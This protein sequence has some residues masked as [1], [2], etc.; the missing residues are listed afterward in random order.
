MLEQGDLDEPSTKKIEQRRKIAREIRK[1][2]A[3]GREGKTLFTTYLQDTIGEMATTFST[4]IFATRWDPNKPN[5]ALANAVAG[6]LAFG[7]ELPGDVIAAQL[8]LVCAGERVCTKRGYEQLTTV[9]VRC[10]AVC[11]TNQDPRFITGRTKEDAGADKA[12]GRRLIALDFN[13]SF[14]NQPEADDNKAIDA[15]SAELGQDHMRLATMHFLLDA[16]QL[17]AECGF[18]LRWPGI[19]KESTQRVL[20]PVKLMVGTVLEVTP[21]DKKTASRMENARLTELVKEEFP[22]K[23]FGDRDLASWVQGLLVE[24]DDAQPAAYS[25]IHKARHDEAWWRNHQKR[26]TQQLPLLTLK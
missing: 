3:G 5:D 23:Q 25:S 8:K 16:Y 17:A 26:S 20:N 7:G 19:V 24:L 18:Q 21:G 15:L 1:K 11:T 12:V 4:S 14:R 6:R 13:A 9:Q 22:G 10:L 2:E